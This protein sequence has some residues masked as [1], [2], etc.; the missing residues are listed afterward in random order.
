[1]VCRT[2]GVSLTEITV[3]FLVALVLFGPEQLPVLARTLGKL[4]GQVK[5]T[6]DSLRRE[7][8]NSVYTPGQDVRN[9]LNGDLQSIR[10]LK[11]EIL[12]PPRGTVGTSSRPIFPE[13]QAVT[14]GESSTPIDAV[15]PSATRVENE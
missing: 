9:T 2:V 12:S 6:S 15:T 1:M 5:R 3:I 11:A 8:Y 14:L 10:N 13:Q 4:T 7:F